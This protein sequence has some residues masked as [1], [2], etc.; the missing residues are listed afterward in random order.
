MGR[1]IKMYTRITV[2]ETKDMPNL[3]DIIE[4]RPGI[5]YK[6]TQKIIAILLVVSGIAVAVLTEGDINFLIMMLF[7]AIPLFFSKEKWFL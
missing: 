2:K 4:R 6:V 7:I 3:K 5:S 1:E